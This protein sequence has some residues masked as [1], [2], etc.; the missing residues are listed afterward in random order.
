MLAGDLYNIA[1]QVR[2]L[3]ADPIISGS[4]I[5]SDIEIVQYVNDS[6][7]EIKEDFRD[8]P[9]FSISGTLISPVPD[10][11]DKRLLALKTAELITYENWVINTGDAILIQT[12]S[13]KLDTSKGT[14]FFK[15]VYEAIKDRYDNLITELNINGKSSATSTVGFRID[16]YIEDA[17]S[18][19]T[20]E[21][22]L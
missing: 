5:R 4:G 16:N 11:T 6:L 20:G 14:R 1:R 21:S 15:D 17:N 7:A 13:I 8:F 19:K 12:G 18:T 3:V 10:V 9:T 22:L 2:R